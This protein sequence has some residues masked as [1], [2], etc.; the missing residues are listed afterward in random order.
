MGPLIPVF[1]SDNITVHFSMEAQHRSPVYRANVV[2][3]IL[4]IGLIFIITYTLH[5]NKT[6][7][8]FNDV[9]EYFQVLYNINHFLVTVMK[10][11]IYLQYEGN[12]NLF[13]FEQR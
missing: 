4:V 10:T 5:H 7:T 12:K 2:I 1:L 13:C 11:N 9:L 6:A 3:F 8:W